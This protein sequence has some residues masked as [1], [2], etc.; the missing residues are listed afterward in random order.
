MVS[1]DPL[2]NGE[3]WRAVE[4]YYKD[5][6]TPGG[7]VTLILVLR[8]PNIQPSYYLIDIDGLKS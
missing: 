8:P 2:H 7:P 4:I 5:V 6:I 1:G 3:K